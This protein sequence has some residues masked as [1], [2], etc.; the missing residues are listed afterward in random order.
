MKRVVKNG[1][2]GSRQSYQNAKKFDPNKYKLEQE[3]LTPD[4]VDSM[5]SLCCKRCAEII[6]WKVNYGKYEPLNCARK[7]NLCT[8][9]C[10]VY[11][12][13][14]ICQN[15]A[16]NRT[17]CAKCQKSPDTLQTEEGADIESDSDQREPELLALKGLDVH[18]I[19]RQLSD[20]KKKLEEDKIR[21]LRERERRTYYRK[22]ATDCSSDEEL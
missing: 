4:V 2:R 11:A 14:R 22:T 17:I 21:S 15:C 3:Q 1:Q 19:A 8:Q 9:K 10:V 7:C 18:I 16:R 6:T 5:T 20:E 13:H 12:Y